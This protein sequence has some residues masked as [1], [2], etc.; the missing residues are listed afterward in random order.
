MTAIPG[1]G[2]AIAIKTAIKNANG[3]NWALIKPKT[4]FT[5]SFQF[6]LAAGNAHYRKII[7]ACSCLFYAYYFHEFQLIW[8]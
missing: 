1:A 5:T 8:K 6:I 7:K 3:R 2:A 4:R